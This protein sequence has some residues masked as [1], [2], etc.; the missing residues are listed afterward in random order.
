MLTVTQTARREFD[1]IAES[2][3]KTGHGLR[4]IVRHGGS[5]Q[6]EF[7]LDFVG[8]DEAREDDRI[9]DADGLKVYLDPD[10]AGWLEEG[11]IDFI[12]GP[13]ERGFK[14]DAPKAGPPKP[15]G[16]L[17]EHVA[18]V[19]EEKVNPALASHGGHVELIAVENGTA[20][21][22]FGG[23]CQGCGMVKATLKGGVEKMLFELVPQI[24][25]VVDVTD[26]AA[27]TNP[28]YRP[29]GHAG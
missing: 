16:P 12:D 24:R 17:S 3:G 22:R 1:R 8:P 5:Y 9:L 20:F 28:Y 4:V 6:P 27:G 19:L 14:V 15:Q 21:L 23:G 7:A 11:T 10:S 26:H 2:E 29:P 18:R 13:S 25:Q